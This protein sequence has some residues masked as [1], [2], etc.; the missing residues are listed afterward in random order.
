MLF[1]ILGANRT[2]DLLVARN[3]IVSSSYSYDFSYRFCTADFSETVRSISK[4]RL[5]GLKA[6]LRSRISVDIAN[7]LLVNI[8]FRHIEQKVLSLLRSIV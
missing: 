5:T 4:N 1:G 3:E 2:E 6:R 8:L 7:F